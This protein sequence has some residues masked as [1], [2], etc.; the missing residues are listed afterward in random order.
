MKKQLKIRQIFGSAFKTIKSNIRFIFLIILFCGVINT[1]LSIF[2]D[3]FLTKPIYQVISHIITWLISVTLSLGI[4]KIF[5]DIFDEKKGQFRDLFTSVKFLPQCL[6]YTILLILFFSILFGFNFLSGFILLYSATLIKNIYIA[7][8]IRLILGLICIIS[9]FYINKN[10]T[11]T[12]WFRIT[13]L[14]VI[15]LILILIFPAIFLIIPIIFYTLMSC[16]YIPFVID[17]GIGPISALKQSFEL[18]MDVKWKLFLLH[19]IYLISL[20]VPI[21]ITVFG[22]HIVLQMYNITNTMPYTIISVITLFL[23]FGIPFFQMINITSY[24]YLLR[25]TSKDIENEQN[26][27][28]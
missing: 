17:K 5:L 2:A 27:E 3:F 10:T 19:F 12:I 7:I 9:L 20:A 11:K 25:Q 26:I 18:A 4:T 6:V 8:A 14:Y 15:S 28:G 22:V 13:S 1:L 24:R 23:T 16:F 21:T